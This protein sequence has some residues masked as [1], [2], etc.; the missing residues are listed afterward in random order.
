MQS[1]AAIAVSRAEGGAQKVDTHQV[2]IGQPGEKGF[3]G[4]VGS[5]SENIFSFLL[6]VLKFRSIPVDEDIGNAVQGF[7]QQGKG[8][9]V[10]DGGVCLRPKNAGQDEPTV[11]A[12]TNGRHQPEGNGV[13]WGRFGA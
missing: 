13:P 11:L 9:P 6:T 3:Y 7:R 1:D 8:I 10:G 5:Q 4:T 12:A 2:G